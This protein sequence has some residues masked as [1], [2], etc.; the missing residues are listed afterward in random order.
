QGD[1]YEY[2]WLGISGNT[3]TSE[4]AEF[5]NLDADFRG[6]L[7]AEVTADGPA[8]KAGLQGR[9]ESLTA[10]SDDYVF[11]GDIITAINGEPINDMNDLITYLVDETKPGDVVAL[12]II[13]D[14][15]SQESI[16]VTLGVRPSLSLI[17]I[18]DK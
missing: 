10:S 6:A 1:D 2:A 12:D 4:A 7:V 17:P 9:N 18:A 3:L 8:A 15:G 16:K 13:H 5:R 11:S 14:D